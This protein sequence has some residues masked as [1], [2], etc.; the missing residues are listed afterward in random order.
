[1]DQD[2]REQYQSFLLQSRVDSALAEFTLDGKVI[3]VS[4]V[5]RLLDGLSAVYTFFEPD[6]ENRGLGIFGVLSQIQLASKMAL[7]YL[8]LGY[9]IEGCRK[10]AYQQAYQPL[11]VYV[12]GRWQA[13]DRDAGNDG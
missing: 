11:E 2:D 8:Y 3:M 5:D 4:L 7:P 1:M 10:M 13:L 12:G 9:W 6:L